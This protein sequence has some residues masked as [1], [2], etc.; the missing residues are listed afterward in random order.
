MD[1]RRLRDELIMQQSGPACPCG[2]RSW[3]RGPV[4][5]PDRRLFRCA[6]CYTV[7][8]VSSELL[9]ARRATQKHTA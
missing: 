1:Y 4:R 8:N 2:R 5:D 6:A 7:L 3:K 9:L